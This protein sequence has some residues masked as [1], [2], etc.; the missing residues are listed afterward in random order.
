MGGN[1]GVVTNGIPLPV[2]RLN[3]WILLTGVILAFALLQRFW[4]SGLTAGAV[5]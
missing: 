4:R 3:R 5:K 1:Q 2:V